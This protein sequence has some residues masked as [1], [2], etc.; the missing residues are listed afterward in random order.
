MELEAGFEGIRGSLKRCTWRGSIAP[1]FTFN[2][3]I[4]RII[5]NRLLEGEVRGQLEGTTHWQLTPQSEGCAVHLEWSFHTNIWWL[6]LLTPMT[7]HLYPRIFDGIL[8]NGGRSLS[9]HLN[10]SLLPDEE[11]EIP[12]ESMLV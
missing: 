1:D 10:A 3:R 7:R 9:A 12:H 11:V 4:T 5:A 6:S 2:L 8:Q